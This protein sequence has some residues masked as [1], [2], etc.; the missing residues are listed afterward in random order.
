LLNVCFQVCFYKFESIHKTESIHLLILLN[1]AYFLISPFFISNLRDLKVNLIKMIKT[2]IR[3]FIYFFAVSSFFIMLGY[4]QEAP[5]EPLLCTFMLFFVIRLIASIVFFYFYFFNTRYYLRPTVI[6][7]NNQIA[8]RLQNYFRENSYLGIRPVGILADTPDFIPEKNV[9]G[10]YLDFQAIFDKAPFEDAFLVVP[11][12]ESALIRKMIALSEKNGVRVHLVP[13]YAEMHDIHFSVATLGNIPLMQ[14]RRFPLG[15]YSNRFWKRIFDIIFSLVA[16][17]LLLPVGLLIAI[18]IKLDSKGPI[19]YR[20]KRVG[21]TGALFVLYKFRTMRD[22]KIEDGQLTSTVSND[23][24]ITRVGRFLRAFSLDELPQFLNVLENKMSVVG[25]RPHRL[26][27]NQSLRGK[28]N[29]YMVRHMVKPGITGWAQVNGWRGPTETKLQYW[30]RTLHDIWY[31]EHW[32]FGFDIYII[33]LTVFS[34]K[35][36]VNAF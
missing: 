15:H 33:W 35:T 29:N 27:L 12:S 28:M 16:V 21:V 24:R 26:N 25:P 11:L 22:E 17:I 3:R 5:K 9:I 8:K 7:G 14:L 4:S 23:H 1:I 31:I 10:S 2:L 13:N 32:N 18:M 6:I 19:L 30:G 34:K 20:A 36:R